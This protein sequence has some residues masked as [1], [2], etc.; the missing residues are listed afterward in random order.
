MTEVV[1]VAVVLSDQPSAPQ[2]VEALDEGDFVDVVRAGDECS[3]ECPSDGGGHA[4]QTSCR[5]RQLAEPAAITACNF[6]LIGPTPGT[7]STPARIVS[8]TKSGLPS[9]SAWSASAV[10]SSSIA[11]HQLAGQRDRAGTRKAFEW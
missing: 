5:L 3:G 8:T 2:L 7:S 1:G 6:G 11:V 4:E 9:V 10:D